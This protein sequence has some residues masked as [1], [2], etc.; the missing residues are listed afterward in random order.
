[1]GGKPA[2]EVRFAEEHFFVG[3]ISGTID[4][5]T[6]KLAA[7]TELNSPTKWEAFFG[8]KQPYLPETM[9]FYFNV[10]AVAATLGSNLN[11]TVTTLPQSSPTPW[12][13][14]TNADKIKISGTIEIVM[15][16]GK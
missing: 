8:S 7:I 12:F 14:C 9:M 15:R 13:F 10:G 6:A 1:M 16:W 3:A 5:L 2:V 4:T 11:A